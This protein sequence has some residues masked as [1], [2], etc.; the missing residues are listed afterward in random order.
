MNYLKKYFGK[1]FH[2]TV[3]TISHMIKLLKFRDHFAKSIRQNKTKIKMILFQYK[4]NYSYLL[5][6]VKS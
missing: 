1:C 5:S 6:I 2:L 3:L 4:E